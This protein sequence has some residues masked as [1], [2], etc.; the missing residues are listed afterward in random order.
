MATQHKW[1][2]M[3]I[4]QICAALE[5]NTTTGLARKQAAARAKKL[6][7]R[8]PDALRPLFIPPE[9][10][11]YRDL[12]K[13]LLDPIVLLT[14]IIATI[15][16]F[17]GERILGGAIISLLICNAIR[18]AIANTQENRVWRK[19]QAYSNPMVKVI[20]GG[21]LYTTDA[22]N[23]LPG[24]V[25]ILHEGDIC[26]ADVRL[27][28]G[29]RVKVSQY[30]LSTMEKHNL[31]EE[32]VQKDGSVIYTSE[33]ED[34]FN[35]HCENIVYAGSV[36]EQGSA[37]G[38][39]VETGAHTYIG[40]TNG[41]VPGAQHPSEAQ[42]VRSIRR[43]IARFSTVQTI[44]LIPLTI[45]L[46]ITMHQSLSF[47]EAFITA[48]ALCCTTITVHIVSF[49]NTIRAT[50]IRASA[51]QTQSAGVAI[52]KHSEAS[53]K[54]CE[55]TD[56]FLFDTA[57]ISDGKYHLE[58][59]YAR[60]AI[61]NHQEL[62]N[63]DV[64]MLA[65]D[66]YLYRT[67]A[68]PPESRNRD[69]FD[70]GLT[71]PIDALIRHVALDQTAI[72]LTRISSHVSYEQEICVVHNRLNYGELDIL[73]S[74]SDAILDC[75][76]HV[77]AGQAQKVLDQ[78]EY[79]AL[80]TLCRIYRESGY[81]VMMV[82]RRDSAGTCFVGM[83]AFAQR[84]GLEFAQC[85]DQLLGEGIRV[86]AFLDNT[87]EN[88]KLLTDCGLIRDAEHDVLTEHMAKQ[89]EL[90]LHVAYGSYRAYL[91]FDKAQIAE[92][93]DRLK[94]R[95]NRIATYTVDHQ[96]KELHKMADLRI[97]CDAIEYRSPKVAQSLYDKMP[98]DGKPFSSRATQQMRRDSDVIV[99]RA[100]A[101]GGGLHG[102][103]TGR[104]Y[105]LSI[106]HNLANAMTYLVS[107]QFFR[108]ILLIVPA[109]FG[110]YMLS[111]VSLLISGLVLDLAAVLLFA[112]ATP[113][114]N[115][116]SCSYPILKRIEK[117]IAY[118]VANIVSASVSA[119]VLW[120]AFATLQILSV[121]DAAQS[122]GLGFL[123]TYLLQGLV[124]F[125]TLRE[126]ATKSKRTTV[127]LLAV[128][129]VYACLLAACMLIGATGSLTG[130]DSISLATALL[131]P[132]AVLVYWITYRILSA[133]GLNLH[134]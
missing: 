107:M 21:K 24:D 127:I 109:I 99:R 70:A 91:G 65:T 52:V 9:R 28:D 60:G 71:G 41:T 47:A 16:F 97:T 111:S 5:T 121:V 40:A 119:L 108:A 124:F 120:L 131:S 112:F 78:D 37:R 82:A 59:I 126:Y 19:L 17:F 133:R 38:I 80:Q 54:L 95:G 94:Q 134:K 83:L 43:Y 105:A 33:Q 57:A 2:T 6:S 12:A 64:R 69:A 115:A 27:F 15:A 30:V 58:S 73:L 32:Q 114:Q 35:P 101:Q 44:L 22:R 66:L 68:C 53:D 117:P 100:S 74:Q 45:L 20:R 25:V 61:Y 113:S 92:L 118:N 128:A 39:V 8:Q 102:I 130:A 63:A 89:H 50:G 36:M 85:C 67:A 18:C 1:H 116:L 34:V 3:S 76:T 125:I 72:N 29:D 81:A 84:V 62:L 103:L 93:M 31:T 4:E 56:L 77:A 23:V 49:A 90:D 55:M 10:H 122:S 132:L 75:C 110:T 46:T 51:E 11:W 79:N 48:L 87:P 13:M 7:V 86:S 96:A 26:P 104:K 129:G 14:L 98:V 88:F 123:A 42:S 106:N